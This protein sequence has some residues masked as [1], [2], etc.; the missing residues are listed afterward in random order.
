M[1]FYYLKCGVVHSSKIDFMWYNL[2]CMIWNN[3]RSISFPIKCFCR[4]ML[5]VCENGKKT[6]SL[7][8]ILC[9][10]LCTTTFVLHIFVS[11]CAKTCAIQNRRNNVKMVFSRS[12]RG[13]EMKSSLSVFVY[14]KHLW[15]KG[16]NKQRNVWCW[17]NLFDIPFTISTYSN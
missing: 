2:E 7:L 12:F 5:S 11:A 14:F 6:S 17:K 9:L 8:E 10:V 13:V 3:W 4:I 15:A 1:P 16:A